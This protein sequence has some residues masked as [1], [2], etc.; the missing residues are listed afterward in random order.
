M[1]DEGTD[2]RSP[3]PVPARV[4]LPSVDTP[5][6]SSRGVAAPPLRREGKDKL[7][8][9]SRYTADLGVPGLLHGAAV[10]CPLPRARLLGIRREGDLPWDEI[11]FVTAQDIPGENVIPHILRDQPCLG[12][13]ILAHAGEAVALVAHA[14]PFV[15]ERA[16]AAVILDLEPLPPVLDLDRA[17]AAK[18]LLFGKDNVFREIR[19]EKGLDLDAL[20][21]GGVHF[22]AT[23]RTGAQEHVYLETC[24][25]LAEATAEGV[26]VSGSLQC[27]YYV[28]E[29]LATVLGL[30]AQR[31]RVV[32]METGGGFG[33]KEDFPSLLAA[34]AALLSLKAG[35]RPVRMVL[36]RGEDMAVTPKRHPSRT[37]IRSVFSED[38]QL[39]ALD[40]DLLLDG[41]AYSTLSPVV[42]ARAAIHASGP[43]RSDNLRVRARA[44][45]TS[46]PPNGAFRGFG[47]PQAAFAV[48]RHMDEAA[49]A[50]G[51]GPEEIRRRNLLRPGDRMA[52]GELLPE[53]VDLEALLDEA[54]GAIRQSSPVT[55]AGLWT[56]HGTGVSLFFHGA[57]FV[58]SG[59]QSL[60]SE[61]VVEARPPGVVTIYTA[62]TEIGQGA[63]TVL[64]Q[65]AAEALDLPMDRVALSPRDTHLVPNSGPTVASRTTAIVGRLVTDA[66]RSLRQQLTAGGRDA[67]ETL[68]TLENP[69]RASARYVPEG[70]QEWDERTFRGRAYPAWSWGAYAAAV[71]VD[72]ATYEVN[73]ERLVA[74]QDVGRVIHQTLARGQVTGGIAQGLGLAL[75]EEVHFHEGRMA[76]ASLTDYLIPTSADVPPVDV[77]FRRHEDDATPPAGLGELPLVGTAPAIFSAVHSALGCS[78]R[79]AP[80]TPERLMDLLDREL[81][82]GPPAIDG[83]P[84]HA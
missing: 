83:D 25:M 40:V 12:F 34:H 76:N 6:G 41:G 60:A 73:V 57:G 17:L 56:R 65:M 29:A 49:H 3:F 38:G 82:D 74:V 4:T 18:T 8:G 10:R 44:V 5:D 80:L 14:D 30:D 62:A 20:P 33:G 50:L 72:L 63:E 1:D 78:P 54:V 35:G 32:Q 27:P 51:L 47:G 9:R 13:D 7:T 66:C 84:R 46:H 39:L 42:L 48:E 23:Y 52:T 77:R 22:E 69:L 67:A 45:A 19:I 75:S 36:G 43:Y 61:V 79:E 59:E 81:R 71:Y 11:V 28:H 15:V 37:R 2:G 58:G 26:L 64:A 70:A 68:G 55:P 16:R 21:A 53:G 31:V 24:A